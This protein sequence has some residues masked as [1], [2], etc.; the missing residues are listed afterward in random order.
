MANKYKAVT[1]FGT[2]TRKTDRTYTHVVVG[3]HR[4][5]DLIRESYENNLTYNKKYAAEYRDKA[6]RVAAGEVMDY[7]EKMDQWATDYETKVATHESRLADALRGNALETIKEA[8][9]AGRPDLAEKA[10]A[11]F[12]NQYSRVEVYPVSL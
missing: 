2:L 3:I 6:N 5:E 8:T 1:P 4:R 9:W 12:R 7:A 10:A 11:K